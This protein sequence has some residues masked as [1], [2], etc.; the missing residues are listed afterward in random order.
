M[1]E[2]LESQ[3]KSY[4]EKK[5]KLKQKIINYRKQVQNLEKQL[6]ESSGKTKE[7][8]TKIEIERIS[9]LQKNKDLEAMIEDMKR[10]HMNSIVKKYKI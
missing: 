1:E 10:K 9:L 3:K 6:G 4:K 2:K 5:S 7:D 8:L